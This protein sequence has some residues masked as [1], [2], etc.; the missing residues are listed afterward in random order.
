MIETAVGAVY[1]VPDRLLDL[2]DPDRDPK[3]ER[4]PVVI[5]SAQESNARREWPVVLAC[6]T[7]TKST[8]KTPFN[9]KL[10]VADG[11]VPRRCW[12]IVPLLQVIYKRDLM[13]H[14]GVLPQPKI[15]ETRARLLDYLGMIP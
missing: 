4:R 15:E 2:S 14:I 11:G 3:V 10:K 12:I 8:L 1:Y 7:T 5:M 9:V 6:P 13:D